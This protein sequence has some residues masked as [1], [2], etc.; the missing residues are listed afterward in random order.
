MKEELLKMRTAVSQ[1]CNDIEIMR[2]KLDE[3]KKQNNQCRV[4][5][6]ILY[7]FTHFEFK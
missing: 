1:K 3:M 6:L 5:F 7:I 2:Q 4:C